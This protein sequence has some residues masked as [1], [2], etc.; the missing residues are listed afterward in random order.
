[1]QNRTHHRRSIE[2]KSSSEHTYRSNLY[3][4]CH[5]ISKSMAAAAGNDVDPMVLVR[6]KYIAVGLVAEEF[7][8]SPQPQVEKGEP[9][10]WDWIQLPRSITSSSPSQ[11]CVARQRR[12]KDER[13]TSEEVSIRRGSKSDVGQWCVG[14]CEGTLRTAASVVRESTMAPA[15]EPI[16]RRVW[17][18]AANPS[19]T[20]FCWHRDVG[21]I[22][23]FCNAWPMYGCAG[24]DEPTT[25]K[26]AVKESV[27]GMPSINGTLGRNERRTKSRD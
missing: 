21:W 1:M 7:C 13:K 8:N 4:S 24:R 6:A 10:G 3:A 12:T 25:I 9:L 20:C 17:L 23:F 19:V 11:W 15:E 2:K 18:A 14:G 26:E 22:S 5:G 16:E 27:A